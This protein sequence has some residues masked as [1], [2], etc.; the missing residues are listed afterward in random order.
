MYITA[1]ENSFELST[2]LG[3]AAALEL[4]FKLP[5]MQIF[6]KIDVAEIP[7]LSD[8]LAISAGK[9]ND[10]DFRAALFENWDYLD[11]QLAV[12]ELIA[13][14]MFSG[15]TEQIEAKLGKFPASVAQKNVIRG[16]LGIPIPSAPVTDS[17]GN[18]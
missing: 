18:D 2:K 17:T 11:L 6:E 10:K 16:L 3:T 1:G 9:I 5:I 13:R 12:Q 8:I 4:K 7:E 14:L 15:T